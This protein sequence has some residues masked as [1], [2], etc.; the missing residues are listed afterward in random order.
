VIEPLDLADRAL[1]FAAGETQIT[2]V[3]ERSLLSRFAV[4]RDGSGTVTRETVTGDGSGVA[5][6][7]GEYADASQIG[8]TI[9]QEVRQAP[10]ETQINSL[11]PIATEQVNKRGTPPLL[12]ELDV[13]PSANLIHTLKVGDWITA[14]VNDGYIQVS[15]KHRIVKIRLNCRN[16]VLTV[17]VNEDN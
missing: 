13:L 16:N 11:L 5:R 6:A 8:G 17:F 3:R 2:V 7:E 14:V 9:L 1:G 15:G 12:L 10:P 4:S